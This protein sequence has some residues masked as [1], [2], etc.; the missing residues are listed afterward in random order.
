MQQSTQKPN[1]MSRSKIKT[2]KKHQK[3]RFEEISK[4]ISYGKI[5][6]PYV[7]VYTAKLHA[8]LPYEITREN[9]K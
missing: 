1:K 3:M 2:S 8:I 5:A 6:L 9:P 4:K 7:A